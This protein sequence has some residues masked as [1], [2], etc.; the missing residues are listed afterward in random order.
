LSLPDNYNGKHSQFGMSTATKI[1]V[2]LSWL[3]NAIPDLM[4]NTRNNYQCHAPAL[5]DSSTSNTAITANATPGYNLAAQSKLIQQGPPTNNLLSNS[6]Y[7]NGII[8]HICCDTDQANEKKQQQQLAIGARSRGLTHWSAPPR[9]SRVFVTLLQLARG[10][11]AT[12][13]LQELFLCLL[14]A[15]VLVRCPLQQETLLGIYNS[16]KNQAW[17][18]ELVIVFMHTLALNIVRSKIID[19]Q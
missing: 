9:G 10:S 1:L 18:M 8:A 12:N 13:W 19:G 6:S 4:C 2:N 14:L 7:P 11:I 16:C 15:F 17:S 5:L 3:L